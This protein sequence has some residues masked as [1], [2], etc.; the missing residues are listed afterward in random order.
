MST[1]DAAAGSPGS[2]RI[3]T[4][5]EL[6]QWS[7]GF[8][9]DREVDSARLTAELLLSHVL[10]VP[11]IKLYADFDRPLEKPELARY[12]ELVQRR[13]RGEPTQ[14][15]IGSQDFYGRPFKV[16]ARALIPRPETELLAERVLRH[17][18]KDAAV[19]VADVGC[20]CG[21]L[22]LTVA[23]ERPLAKIV[24]TD[25][26]E[27]AAALCRENAV[28]LGLAPQVEVRLGDLA[29]PLEGDRFD[30]VVTNLPYVPDRERTTLPLHIRAHE[31]HLA[32]FG[33]PDGLDLYRR[34]IPA[35]APMLAPGGLLACEHGAEHGDAMPL[36]FTPD[37]WEQPV[38]ERDLAGFD[39][40][41]WAIRRS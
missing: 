28:L 39:R 37:L 7:R 38:V 15:L 30:A 25:V 4:I 35:V 36:L 17:L 22:G 5:R 20:G 11:R 2:P 41:T 34:F 26:S 8:F 27:G 21:T 40:F 16:D 23:A 9:D 13:V 31:P 1:A 33:G 10:K 12:K 24:L 32:L 3:W 6:L 18:P 19:R 14:Y 29:T